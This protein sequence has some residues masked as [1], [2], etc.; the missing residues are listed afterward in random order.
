[1]KYTSAFVRR[2]EAREGRPWQGVLKYKGE[3]GRQRQAT[4]VFN[5]SRVKTRAAARKA[6]DA[7]R[8]EMEQRAASELPSTTTCVPEYVEAYIRVLGETQA[9]EQSTVAGYMST[10][11]HIRR[12]FAGVALSDLTAAQA[13]AWEQSLTSSGLGSSTVGKAHRLLKQVCKHAV[14]VGDLARNPLDAVKPPKRKAP[15]PNSLDAAG[16]ARLLSMLDAGEPSP[17]VTGAYLALFTGM[18]EGEACGLRW[19]DVDLDGRTLWVSAAIGRT[20]GGTYVKEP[21]NG[22]SRRDVP[23]PEPLARA[24]SRRRAAMM[25][26]WLAAGVAEGEASKRAFGE[27]FVLGRIDGRYQDPQALGRDWAALARAH[28]LYG[29]KGRRVTFHDLRH[30]FATTA[31]AEH[32]DVKTVSSILGHANAA[33]TL[34]IYASADPDAKRRAAATIGEAMARPAPVAEVVEFRREGTTGA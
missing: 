4:K 11:N 28:G 23:I 13:Q 2:L 34:N 22:G 30:T 3:D 25:A 27:L 29:D 14:A 16:R 19:R 7:W 31:I 6:L 5:R 20:R 12:G 26:D 9:V 1:M 18:R 21:K 17:L 10:L 33:M 8:A 24:L 15:D 32:V